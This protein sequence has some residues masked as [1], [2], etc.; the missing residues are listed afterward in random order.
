[1]D[2]K[3]LYNFHCVMTSDLP[4]DDE[5]K[6]S[7]KTPQLILQGI[8]RLFEFDLPDE[9]VLYSDRINQQP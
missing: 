8:K 1:M 7:M 5:Q 3:L 9:G 2:V 6:F 4:E